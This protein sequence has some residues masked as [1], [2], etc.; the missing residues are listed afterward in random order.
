[1]EETD[2]AAATEQHKAWAHDRC[3]AWNWNCNPAEIAAELIEE[4][5]CTPYSPKWEALKAE[6]LAFYPEQGEQAWETIT[7]IVEVFGS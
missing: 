5:D 1:M 6:F 2:D 7:Q 4:E 3:E